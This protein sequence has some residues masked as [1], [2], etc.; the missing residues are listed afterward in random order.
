MALIRPDLFETVEVYCSV[1]TKGE[2]T[3]GVVVPDFKGHFGGKTPL[4]R[5]LTKVKA[6]EFME[7]FFSRLKKASAIC[8]E[9]GRLIYA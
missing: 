1:E 6:E 2:L 7:E 3:S 5:L 9:N 4:L 8:E